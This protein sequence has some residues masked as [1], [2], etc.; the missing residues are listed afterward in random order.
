MVDH[1][2]NYDISGVY[3]WWLSYIL[4]FLYL[5]IFQLS[6]NIGAMFDAA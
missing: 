6:P 2:V 5:K 1:L 4:L 3:G